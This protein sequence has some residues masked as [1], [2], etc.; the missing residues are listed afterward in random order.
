MTAVFLIP[1]RSGSTRVKSKNLRKI[2]NKTILVNKIEN[3][4]KTKIGDVFVSTNSNKIADLSKKNGA[5]ILGMRPKKLSTSNSS[6]LSAVLNFLTEYKKK[7][8]KIPLFLIIAPATNPFLNSISIIN[9]LK[10]L[11]E[12]KQFNSIVSIYLSNE[13][14][15]QLVNL[16]FQ[17]LFY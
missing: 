17:K 3:C 6:M 16:I 1:A 11:K 15:F 10:I 4:L 8:K 14:P 13:Q 9:A 7:F 2:K 5:K 12:N